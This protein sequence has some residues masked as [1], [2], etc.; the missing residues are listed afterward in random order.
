ML[1]GV[2]SKYGVADAGRSGH[3]VTRR[4]I[5]RLYSQYEPAKLNRVASLCLEHGE[6]PLLKMVRDQYAEAKPESAPRPD[7][8]RRGT[9]PRLPRGRGA[10]ASSRTR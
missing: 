1:A 2:R 8:A 4:E 6:G 5:E 9:A 3:S 7:S 10:P